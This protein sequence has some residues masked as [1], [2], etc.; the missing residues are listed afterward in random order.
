MLFVELFTT[1]VHTKTIM[2]D[3]WS[4]VD[5]LRGHNPNILGT[6]VIELVF[7]DDIDLS[8]DHTSLDSCP[9]DCVRSF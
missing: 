5:I 2:C 8:C 6:T 1:R 7:P 3:Q 4:L 9:T